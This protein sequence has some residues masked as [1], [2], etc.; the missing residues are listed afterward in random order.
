MPFVTGNPFVQSRD[1]QVATHGLDKV[2]PA[3]A[4][5][6]RQLKSML[7]L[8]NWVDARELTAMEYSDLAKIT[9]GSADLLPDLNAQIWGDSAMGATALE[10]VL[11]PPL[12]QMEKKAT[13]W[14][15][16]LV[17][18]DAR[19]AKMSAASGAPPAIGAADL[20]ALPGKDTS[21]APPDWH[22][23][24]T[25]G[26]LRRMACGAKGVAW[27]EHHS[28][29]RGSA[30]RGRNTKESMLLDRLWQ[31]ALATGIAASTASDGE[32][33][34]AALQMLERVILE[35]AQECYTPP[36]LEREAVLREEV[37]CWKD[38]RDGTSF[39]AQSR[40][41]CVISAIAPTI[42]SI[43]VGARGA[44]ASLG[45]IQDLGSAYL[46]GEAARPASL[47]TV[48]G[49]R[50]LE[51]AVL[52]RAALLELADLGSGAQPADRV[53][54]F[55]ARSAS[56]STSAPMSYGD[57][58]S[59]AG[60]NAG[61]GT[62]NPTATGQRLQIAR[63]EGNNPGILYDVDSMLASPSHNPLD[64]LQLLLTG[65]SAAH[66]TRTNTALSRQL[67][68]GRLPGQM[69]EGK[70]STISTYAK[71]HLGNYL[72][73]QV[74]KKVV[75]MGLASAEKM[76]ALNLDRLAEAWRGDDWQEDADL[77]NL[78]LLPVL[79]TIHMGD[80]E[81]PVGFAPVPAAKVYM[82]PVLNSKLPKLVGACCEALGMQKDGHG[83]LRFHMQESVDWVA[84]H[85][86]VALAATMA[87]AKG[88]RNLFR[89]MLKEGC[90]VDAPA[91]DPRNPQ[92][93]R[94]SCFLGVDTST[95]ARH[96]WGK[97][98]TRLLASQTRKEDDWMDRDDGAAPTTPVSLPAPGVAAFSRLLSPTASPPPTH[99]DQWRSSA[100]DQHDTSSSNQHEHG[101]QG[102]GTRHAKVSWSEGKITF[103][104]SGD[105]L[106][107]TAASG[108]EMRWDVKA[109]RR[110]ITDAGA[111]PNNLCL[112]H[113]LAGNLGLPDGGCP[114]PGDPAHAPGTPAHTCSR[115]W[116]PSTYR[117]HV[118]GGGG[119]RGRG[120][121]KGGGR[122]GGKGGGK[123]N[124]GGKGGGK[125]GGYDRDRGKSGGKGKSKGKAID[126]RAGRQRAGGRGGWGNAQ[127]S[128]S[129]GRHNPSMTGDHPFAELGLTQAV[130]AALILATA[131]CTF[132]TI[133]D[134][135]A[136][137]AASGTPTHTVVNC[138]LPR[139]A[140]AG[141]NHALGYIELPLA[142][143]F[144]PT[145]LLTHNHSDALPAAVARNFP[146]EI[147][148]SCDHRR[149]DNSSRLHYCGDFR[150][151][152]W[153]R[154]WRLLFGNPTCGPTAKSHKANKAERYASGAHYAGEATVVLLWTAPADYVILEQPDSDLADDWRPP[155]QI[156]KF[157]SHAVDWEKEWHL[158]TRGGI[159]IFT[160]S[161]PTAA[162]RTAPHRMRIHDKNERERVHSLT[163]P[164]VAD[165]I[166]RQLA[167]EVDI[168]APPSD[169]QPSFAEEVERFASTYSR[170]R[171][172][173]AHY[174]DP[175]AWHKTPTT[176]AIVRHTHGDTPATTH[177]GP[178]RI[179]LSPSGNPDDGP[180]RITQGEAK[181]RLT[182]APHAP[183]DRPHQ[184]H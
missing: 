5:I 155:C 151:I 163:P 107:A 119:S 167:A 110:D 67:G 133:P 127:G 65:A 7:P 137:L 115:G 15:G 171:P 102:D 79:H 103:E 25:W 168:R 97:L 23:Q 37:Q 112:P 13:S 165:A 26:R 98:K 113:L 104:S 8:I 142:D 33:A 96:E 6:T 105:V 48:S 76:T 71:L 24:I 116:K 124:N 140:V 74:Q 86:G 111:D 145:I 161:H 149:A 90:M 172:L 128:T 78:L 41:P 117:I 176:W 42:T 10:R 144:A 20:V 22:D 46:A 100:Y 162:V 182:G 114:K 92:A 32:K 93:I 177:D 40:T 44:M 106:L 3:S 85:S 108:E 52:P 64:V 29:G 63:S 99:Q 156:V 14:P 43:L 152:L 70:Y 150:D 174:A 139:N 180:D 28:A 17:D 130:L 123:G 91:R 4:E 60:S 49:L 21:R 143:P 83:S 77:V 136:R 66:P 51:K 157:S 109:A 81:C 160:P 164:S 138:N 18:F 69:L 154:R 1:D 131:G 57:D 121:A 118:D 132:V 68:L 62:P 159:P 153:S 58:L 59:A 39:F 129:L 101:Y 12:A 56:L 84:F 169:G 45:Y 80:N 72:S 35:A 16:F 30:G 134:E 95:G 27:L 170:H 73:R 53:E 183:P 2:M 184:H 173:P 94:S 135:A 122:S 181:A 125:G 158:Y 55:V 9:L 89:G 126:K 179:P 166:M 50:R 34:H 120:G 87:I 178:D 38:A 47:F 36:G 11:L 147:V 54:V 82:D 148:M 175:L 146:G 141:N 88:Q 75:D 61:S 19:T 31:A